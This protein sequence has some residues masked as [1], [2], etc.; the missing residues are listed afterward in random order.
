M[1][2]VI[3]Q[4]LQN[5][6]TFLRARSMGS[7]NAAMADIDIAQV[8]ALFELAGQFFPPP[9]GTREEPTSV[10]GVPAVWVHAPGATDDRTVVYLHGGGYAIGSHQ[11]HRG[12]IGHLSAATGARVLAPDYR[13]APEHPFPAAVDDAVA[14]VRSV[15]SAT[16]PSRVALG[17]DSAGG[18]LTL[19]TLVALRD[20]GDPMPACA[21]ALSPWTDLANSG[22]SMTTRAENDPLITLEGTQFGASHYL[23][24]ASAREPLASPLY[25]DLAGLPP[26]LIQVGD[27]E[28]LLDDAVRFADRADAA[29]V[30]VTLDVW[31]E[32]IHV[33]QFFAGQVP[34][35]DEALGKLAAFVASRA[36]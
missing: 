11:S 28:V 10:G 26:L 12:L 25:A 35:A 24:G 34:E 19:A 21:F 16:E 22:T 9:E 18:G 20:H 36:G 32:M 7:A 8:R 13:L 14:V 27:A 31:A 33:W 5:I 6:I 23:G 4:Q 15:L 30:D 1:L 3:S 17:G 29:G 2:P